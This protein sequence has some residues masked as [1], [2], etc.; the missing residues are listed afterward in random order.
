MRRYN[1]FLIA[2]LIIIGSCDNPRKK[3]LSLNE[4]EYEELGMPDPSKIW[5]HEDYRKA[6]TVLAQLKSTKPLSLPQKESKE[7][8]KYF[9]R[10]ISVENISFLGD[11]SIPLNEKAFRIQSYILIQSDLTDIY[12]NI[13]GEDQYYNRELID[14]YLFSLTISQRML[15]LSYKI[16]E[17]DYTGDIGMKAG[18]GAVQYTYLAMLSFILD[19]QKNSST[20]RV[21]DL[22]RLT[23]SLSN[24][25]IKNEEWMEVSSRENL[26]KQIQLVID[27]VSSKHIKNEYNKLIEDL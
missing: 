16:N 15:D 23:D 26:K 10:L 3:D 8:G 22:E 9:N 4:E 18:S 25:V 21:E 14:L 27:S 20:Y 2:V 5:K 19:K 7:S 6:Y 24:S 13:Y 11:K 1:F 12:T 17:S